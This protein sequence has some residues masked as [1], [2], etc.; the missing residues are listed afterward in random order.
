MLTADLSDSFFLRHAG[1]AQR[2]GVDPFDLLKPMYSESNIRAAA[3]NP[4]G[5]ASGVLQFMPAT[6]RGLGWTQG[7]AAF[8][9]LPADEQ[10]PFV[11]AYFRPHAFRIGGGGQKIP[12]LTTAAHV[13]TVMF[14]PAD[15]TS[16]VAAGEGWPSV[17]LCQHGGKLSWA[18]DANKVLDEN[19]DG[20]ITAGELMD[21]LDKVCVGPRWDEICDRMTALTPQPPAN[22]LDEDPPQAA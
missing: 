16:L 12:Q 18:E 19:G 6:L 4:N 9:A 10:V 22:D 1:V 14:L 20:A 8:R 3:H 2:L 15:L 13:Y 5:D 17:I 7:D 11:E 21:R